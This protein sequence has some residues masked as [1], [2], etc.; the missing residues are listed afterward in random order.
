MWKTFTWKDSL[1]KHRRNVHMTEEQKAL[2]MFHCTLCNFRC[3]GGETYL[4]MHVSKVHRV[5]T[6]S[7]DDCGLKYTQ[8]VSL[9]KHQKIKHGFK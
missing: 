3:A 8:K 1:V 5:R 2:E 7:C 6:L 9:R 4:K